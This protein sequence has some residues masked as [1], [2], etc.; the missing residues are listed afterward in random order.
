MIET[1]A[2]DASLVIW[3]VDLFSPR[4][5]VPHSVWQIEVRE[6]DTRFSSRTRAVTDR[7]RAE[8]DL[9]CALHAHAAP[10]LPHVSTNLLSGLTEAVA[11]APY[12]SKP[13]F[14]TSP[15]ICAWR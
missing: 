5:P 6:K 4:G 1:R 7:M 2:D 10:L 13:T 14:P 8:H 11:T 3:Q 12:D 9:A 15:R